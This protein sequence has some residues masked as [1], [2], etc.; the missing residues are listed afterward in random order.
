MPTAPLPPTARSDSP[1]SPL[2]VTVFPLAVTAPVDGKS[3][4]FG[5][6]VPITMFRL[7]RASF[8]AAAGRL[9]VG[10]TDPNYL[11]A[12]IVAWVSRPC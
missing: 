1:V 12:D 11:A 5:A 9:Q 2:W 4:A 10:I 8:E 7:L 6:P 3:Y